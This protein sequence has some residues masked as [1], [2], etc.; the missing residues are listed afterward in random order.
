MNA[1][2]WFQRKED[3]A[4]RQTPAG[5]PFRQFDVTCLKCGSYDLR[6]AA[7]MD[8]ESGEMI[9]VLV[10]KKCRQQEILPVR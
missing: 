3:Y 10:C 1:Q 6:L 9:V 7:Q 5:S 4:P 8:E 2:R